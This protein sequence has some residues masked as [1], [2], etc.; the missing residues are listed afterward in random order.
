M[1]E[2]LYYIVI[3]ATFAF[4]LLTCFIVYISVVQNKKKILYKQELVKAKLEIKEQTMRHIAYELHDNLGQI[5]SLI[6]INLTTLQL[7]DRDATA[8]KIEDTKE[9]TR[10]LIA[11]IKSLSV[12]L[13][14]DRVVHLG[15][16]KVLKEEVERLN[17]IGS[18]SAYIDIEGEAF[19]PGNDTTII[20]YRMAQELINNIVKHS[21]A[22]RIRVLL[23]VSEK[24]FTLA[25]SDDGMGFNPDEKLRSGGSGLLNLQN[26]AKLINAHLSIQ[27]S[28]GNGTQVQ[29]Q[30]PIDFL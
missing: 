1:V 30:L 12:S 18:F 16:I 24:I 5:A 23:R 11:D 7:D 17:K 19:N 22:Q 21:G 9:L 4:F 14:S 25:I 15:L 6:K 28:E 8:L 20:L 29:I 26:R 10:K 3:I 27:S 2:K 13:N